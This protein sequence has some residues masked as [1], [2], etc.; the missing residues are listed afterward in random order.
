MD[1]NY[2]LFIGGP[3]DGQRLKG[4]GLAWPVE[5]KEL[6]SCH[7]GSATIKPTLTTYRRAVVAE[8]NIW[9]AEPLTIQ[10]AVERLTANYKPQPKE[11]PI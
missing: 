2:C 6:V 8:V 5:T 4:G 7:G 10:E 11:W 9:I 1:E 3:W